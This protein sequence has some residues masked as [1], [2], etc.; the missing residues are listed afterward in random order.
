MEFSIKVTLKSTY[1]NITVSNIISFSEKLL[2][3][4]DFLFK[5]SHSKIQY[6]FSSKE[7]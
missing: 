6:L 1:G 3:M 7:S 4:S 2:L 5:S